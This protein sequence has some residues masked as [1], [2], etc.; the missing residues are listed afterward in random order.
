[1]TS[2]NIKFQCLIRKTKNEII[3]FTKKDLLENFTFIISDKQLNI[4]SCDMF[5]SKNS[6]DFNYQFLPI[7]NEPPARAINF[8]SNLTVPSEISKYLD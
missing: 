6:G 3:E 1:M 8:L 7:V 5:N 2:P 4:K